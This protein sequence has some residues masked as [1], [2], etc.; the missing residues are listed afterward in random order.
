MYI[1]HDTRRRMEIHTH[2]SSL[3]GSG[4]GRIGLKREVV[5]VVVEVEVDVEVEEVCVEV[6]VVVVVLIGNRTMV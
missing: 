2:L 5:D 3:G 6:G 1:S 4:F